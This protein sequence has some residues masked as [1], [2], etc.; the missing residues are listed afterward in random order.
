MTITHTA[1][2]A[3]LRRAGLPFPLDHGEPE[4]EPG[5]EHVTEQYGVH[6]ELTGDGRY[7]R[8]WCPDCDTE[9]FQPNSP[10]GVRY[11]RDVAKGHKP[12]CCA[13]RAAWGRPSIWP[14]E[15]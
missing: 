7:L 13:E 12:D 10:R 2:L 1:T 6:G 3:R 11:A 14:D 15:E 4:A 9:M 5:G 8:F